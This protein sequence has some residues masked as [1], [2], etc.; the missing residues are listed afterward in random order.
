MRLGWGLAIFISGKLLEMTLML[1]VQAL[2][3]FPKQGKLQ[4]KIFSFLPKLLGDSGTSAIPHST[5]SSGSLTVSIF[6][7]S[8]KQPWASF[9][10]CRII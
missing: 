1:V 3:L 2:S 7:S 10:K 8:L 6:S 5:H 4:T 9:N